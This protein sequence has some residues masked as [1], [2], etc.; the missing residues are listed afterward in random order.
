VAPAIVVYLGA[1]P[2]GFAFALAEQLVSNAWISLESWGKLNGLAH[3][4]QISANPCHLP[5]AHQQRGG[6]V[7][8]GAGLASSGRAGL[9]AWL[10]TAA[11]Q[12]VALHPF[13]STR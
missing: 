8:V 5:M 12:R 11:H 2:R 9:L 10:S 6:A 4:Q 3:W 13:R 1:T 7:K